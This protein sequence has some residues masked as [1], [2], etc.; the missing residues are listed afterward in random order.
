MDINFCHLEERFDP[1]FTLKVC[2]DGDT[3]T[4]E[5]YIVDAKG[6]ITVP[7]IPMQVWEGE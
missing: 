2:V 1:G 4:I 7:S 6:V 3:R 5:A